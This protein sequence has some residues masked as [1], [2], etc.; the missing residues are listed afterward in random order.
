MSVHLNDLSK[1]YLQQVAEKNDDS[2]LET[3]MNKRLK[4]NE[5]AIED[6]KNTEANKSMVRSARRAMGVEE[7]KKPNDGNLANNYPPYNKVTR[8]DVIAGRLGK[9]EMG[10]K[11]KDKNVKEGYSNWREDLAEVVGDIGKGQKKP[12]TN[13]Q[14]KEKEV[15]NTVNINPE[16]SEGVQIIESVELSE[17]YINE[18]VYGAVDY[19]IAEGLNEDGIEILI[20]ELGLD[21]FVSFVFEI[22]NEVLTE[23][24]TLLGKKKNPQKLPKGTA[25]TQATKAAVAKHGTTRKFKSSSTSGVV[26]KNR[27]TTKAVEKA[28]ETQ[29]SKKPV[30]D[31]IARG[32][33][34]A[35]DAYKAGMKR[36]RAAMDAAKE[37][38]KT[39]AK[40]AAVTHEAGRRAGQSAAGQAIKK[41]GSAVIKAGV[42][43]AKKDIKSLKKESFILDEKAE[44]EQQQKLFGLA[45]SVKRGQ[46]P[47]SEASAE[48]LKIV[49]SMSEKKIRDFAKTKHEGIPKKKV[50]EQLEP[51]TPD[52]I[53]AQKRIALAQDLL[54]K[55]NKKALNK[56][57]QKPD[58]SQTSAV[59]EGKIP[60]TRQAGDFRYPKK[61][62]EEKANNKADRL[63]SS[64]NPADRRRGNKIR[65]IIKTVADRDT[66]QATSNAMRKLYKGQQRRA[67]DLA[68]EVI[69]AK[70][71]NVN[72]GYELKGNLVDETKKPTAL[73][74]VRQQIIAKHGAESLMGTPEHDAA[75]KA[76]A[77][78]S[79]TQ[80]K[81]SPKQ[82]Y[83]DDV[84]SKDGL[85]GIRGYRSGD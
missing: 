64:Q 38:G 32:V 12:D 7:Q 59:E 29:P 76:A 36:H 1:V 26:K 58:T 25:P 80:P 33:F 69:K 34:R 4:N 47:R 83:K 52:Q 41:V 6:M 53:T 62:G 21:E 20:D 66:A 9:D 10:G 40:A 22:G 45:L 78:K 73:D 39:I 44:S 8:G 65:N 16:I 68:H 55:A 61:T 54:N 57:V 60:V 3:D 43:K 5:K 79:K 49:D 15:N 27:S 56:K 72:A 11:K 30:R 85:G 50:E 74:I 28:K 23:A 46:T 35:V 14:I 37:T 75:T 81:P 42:E 17:E 31:A 18:T 2:Y 19:F 77:A 67:N 70:N 51:T 24:R 84:Y 48:V 71:N 63:S 82:R 13:S